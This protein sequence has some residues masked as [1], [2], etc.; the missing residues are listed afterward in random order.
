LDLGI[1]LTAIAGS[2]FPWCGVNHD[3]GPASPFAQIGNVRFYTYTGQPFNYRS[4]KEGLAAGHTF[5]SSG[6]VLE[7]T[8]NQALPGDHLDVPQGSILSISA[9]AYG[10]YSQVPLNRLEIVGHG[11]ILGRVSVDDPGQSS[12]QLSLSL[13][14]P[15]GQG[16][17]IAARTFGKPEQVAHTTPIY[18]TVD[19]G[20]FY[21]PQSAPKYLTL[22]E[23]YL[24]ELENQLENHSA[25]PEFQAWHY[26]AP[27]KKRISE[28]REIIKILRAKFK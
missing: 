10:H 9:K 5:V 14:L 17:W 12:S 4:W 1:P 7:F 23:Q 21:N 26:K 16:I 15:V 8:I 28:T 24:D 2:D 3:S 25:D 22:S 18:I 6:P 19:N 27:L 13:E 20:S 11:K